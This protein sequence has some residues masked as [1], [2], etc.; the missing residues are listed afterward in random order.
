MDNGIESQLWTISILGEPP[1]HLP[2]SCSVEIS[3]QG[4]I[5]DIAYALQV[6]KLKIV[7]AMAV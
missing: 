3:A 2:K 6:N 4:M 5:W 7:K 1:S